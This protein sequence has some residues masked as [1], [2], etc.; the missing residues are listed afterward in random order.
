MLKYI[1]IA[2]Q[3]FLY[4]DVNLLIGMD[5]VVKIRTMVIIMIAVRA[6]LRKLYDN[7]DSDNANDEGN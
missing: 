1:V 7:D 2:I 5:T 3:D 6:L 4:A